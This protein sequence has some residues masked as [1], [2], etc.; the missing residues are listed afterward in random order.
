MTLYLENPANTFTVWAGEAI[1]DIRHPL[2]IE[3]LWTAEELAAV[4]LYLPA[5]ADAVPDGKMV[6]STDV[7]RVAGV[8]K[9]VN[10]L[11]DAP[12]A[13]LA[14][15]ALVQLAGVQLLVSDWDVTG[16]DHS[17]GISVAFVADTDTVWAFFNDAQPDADYIVMPMDGV[18][19]QPDHLEISKPGLS[20]V[21]LLV[22][23][24]Q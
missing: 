10:T 15:L 8:V 4:G 9:Y 6:T 22:F 24:V 5:D 13:N 11:A 2:N 23:R 16:V 20:A 21:S 17:T 12:P 3:Q 1:D 18:T 19:K 7:E 14:P